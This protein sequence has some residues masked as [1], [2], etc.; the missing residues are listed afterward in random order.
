MSRLYR[1]ERV[2][3]VTDDEDVRN[4]NF[5]LRVVF[6]RVFRVARKRLLWGI[7]DREARE[8]L[9]ELYLGG[10]IERRLRLNS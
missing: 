7:T 1:A 2:G 8:G 5:E 9:L 4:C 6:E 10:S 3:R